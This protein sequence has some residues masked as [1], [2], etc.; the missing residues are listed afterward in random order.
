MIFSIDIEIGI[1]KHYTVISC[2]QD[3]V[4]N[5]YHIPDKR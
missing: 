5:G 3:G 2:K 4:V 1:F